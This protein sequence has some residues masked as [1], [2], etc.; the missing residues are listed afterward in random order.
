MNNQSNNELNENILKAK[1]EKNRIIS[2]IKAKTTIGAATLALIFEWSPLNEALLAN[3]GI[4]SHDYFKYSANF[5]EIALGRLATGGLVGA[6]SL[7]QQF[8]TGSLV[9]LA[10][11]QNAGTLD[12]LDKF[13]KVKDKR[14]GR[15][16][17]IVTPIA[18]GSSGSVIQRN[19][20]E[21][22]KNLGKDMKRVLEASVLIGSINGI[23]ATSTSSFLT[24]LDQTEQANLSDKIEQVIKNPLSYI[25][26]FGIYKA[27]EKI[28]DSKKSD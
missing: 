14:E 13:T 22:D 11:H 24:S 10:I 16:K 15:I 1:T 28:K 5:N 12:K 2:K 8:L 20:Y 27:V 9:A 21:K 26:I 6:T 23:L 25:A 19:L 7:A 4:T 18:F 17:K 3:V